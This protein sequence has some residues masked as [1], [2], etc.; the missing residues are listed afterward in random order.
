MLLEYSQYVSA[1]AYFTVCSLLGGSPYAVDGNG[2]PLAAGD[3]DFSVLSSGNCLLCREV[4]RK[5]TANCPGTQC[6][7]AEANLYADIYALFDCAAIIA[8]GG[9]SANNY[10]GG[11]TGGTCPGIS[12]GNIQNNL[13]CLNSDGSLTTT[14]LSEDF[15]LFGYDSEEYLL[16]GLGVTAVA[17][18][19]PASV[20]LFGSAGLLGQPG[21]IL[22]GGGVLPAAALSVGTINPFCMLFFLKISLKY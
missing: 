1:G 20:G 7:N 9:T 8:A 2:V 15:H 11:T 10:N 21:V 17:A 14:T 6:D 22:G 18:V 13:Q 5:T 12:N 16:A 4:C 19:A 3:C